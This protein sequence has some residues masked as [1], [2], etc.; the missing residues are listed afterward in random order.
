MRRKFFIV[1]YTILLALYLVAIFFDVE[2]E[3]FIKNYL[4]NAVVL[5]S[6]HLTVS[7]VFFYDFEKNKVT[8]N[9]ANFLGNV[10]FIGYFVLSSIYL[11]NTTIDY[12]WCGIII[13][14]ILSSFLIVCAMEYLK[15]FIA[16]RYEK[17]YYIIVCYLLLTA[18]IFVK[19]FYF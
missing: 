18:I 14:H 19:L 7:L 16:R 6:L 13:I 4:M 11:V 8:T 15:M 10:F 2:K 1:S 12:S 3:I 17:A 5:L 9:I